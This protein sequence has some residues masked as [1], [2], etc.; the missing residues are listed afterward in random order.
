LRLYPCG[1]IGDYPAFRRTIPGFEVRTKVLL[2]RSPLTKFLLQRSAHNA[3]LHYTLHTEVGILVR[4]TCMPYPHR[5]RSSW[6]RIKS[7]VKI[8]QTSLPCGKKPRRCAHPTCVSSALIPLPTSPARR[9]SSEG[10]GPLGQLKNSLGIYQYFQLLTYRLTM[11]PHS[12]AQ[13]IV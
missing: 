3:L 11:R 8:A 2:T 13:G 6:T 5:Q 9:A 1:T 12:E 10:F 4:S 7:S